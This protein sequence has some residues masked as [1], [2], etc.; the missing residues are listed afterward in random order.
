MLH[1]A[2]VAEIAEPTNEVWVSAASA[3]ELAI[4][5]RS[6][7]LDLDVSRLMTDLARSDVRLLGIGVDDGVA[8]GL[9]EWPHRDPVDRMLV[10]QALRGSFTLV[11]RD[12]TVLAHPTLSAMPA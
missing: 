9:L 6:G 5:V 12:A 7:R 1:P 11:T 2:A 4:K 10:A 3:W 8:A